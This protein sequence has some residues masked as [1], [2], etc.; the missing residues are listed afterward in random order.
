MNGDNELVIEV[1]SRSPSSNSET[2]F[3]SLYRQDD[4]NMA[5]QYSISKQTLRDI[6]ESY[7]FSLSYLG[8]LVTQMGCDCP[9]DVDSSIA[10]F[11]T[12]EQIHTLL[13]ALTSLDAFETSTNYDTCNI[14]QL[15]DELDINVNDVVHICQREEIPLPFGKDTNLHTSLI[16]KIRRI[17]TE[18][19]QGGSIAPLYENDFSES[20]EHIID[21]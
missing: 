17:A 12:G 6:S 3:D 8:D 21:V 1:Q 10:N 15:A 16:D 9:I 13:Q 2:L 4:Y 20:Q 18:Q 11:M 5:S 14:Y 19:D 7:L